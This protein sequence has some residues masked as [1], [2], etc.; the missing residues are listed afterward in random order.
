MTFS[1]GEAHLPDGHYDLFALSLKTPQDDWRLHEPLKEE[2][3]GPEEHE[4]ELT[5]LFPEVWVEDKP[6]SPPGWLNIKPQ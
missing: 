2:S 3:G 1:R 6:H 4:R 5:Q